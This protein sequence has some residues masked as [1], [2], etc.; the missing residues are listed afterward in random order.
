M[1][2]WCYGLVREKNNKIKLTE[3]Y[4]RGDKPFGYTYLD[5]RQYFTDFFMIIKDIYLQLKRYH[6]INWEEFE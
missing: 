2:S 1:G 6:I 3:V 4:C 5:W